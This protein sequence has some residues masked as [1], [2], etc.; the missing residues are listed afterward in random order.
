ARGGG[1]QAQDTGVDSSGTHVIQ[2]GGALFAAT[3]VVLAGWAALLAVTAA[4]GRLA[5]PGASRDG[6][7]VA[8]RG[9][10]ARARLRGWAWFLTL[11]EIACDHG[12]GLNAASDVLFWGV[13]LALAVLGGTTW[14]RATLYWPA[15]VLA[16]AAATLVLRLAVLG[17]THGRA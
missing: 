8:L 7:P 4:T 1:I 6:A 11:V 5:R 15:A 13:Y 9:G 12:R 16:A 3:L 14:R 10:L 17:G 2:V